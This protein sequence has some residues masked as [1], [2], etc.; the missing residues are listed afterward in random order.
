M[1]RKR[2]VVSGAV[3]ILSTLML[4]GEASA[5]V[6]ADYNDVDHV[7]VTEY[8]VPDNTAG[9]D[10]GYVALAQNS[11]AKHSRG[12]SVTATNHYGN[13]LWSFGAFLQDCVKGG[14]VV[15][16]NWG[17]CWGWTADFPVL[18]NFKGCEIEAQSN[19]S[20]P[21]EYIWRQWRGHFKYCVT[22]VCKQKDPW[23][24]IGGRGDGTF[25]T[26]GGAG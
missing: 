26:N 24:Y 11:C 22:W 20:L 18:W 12:H 1:T 16:K 3:L 5:A 10:D 15:H 19:Q 21:R 23:V 14:K 2:W 6:P 8:G 13:T 7:E 17:N 9:F 4:G 25:G